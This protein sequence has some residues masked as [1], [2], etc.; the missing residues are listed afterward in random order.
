M[1]NPQLETF[2]RVADAGSFN[3]AAE[4]S[5][6][7]S[8]AVI[9]QINLL[10][11]DLD[12]KLFVRTHRGLTLTKAGV[13]LYNDAKYIIQYCRDSVVRAKNAMQEDTNVIRIGVSPITPTQV[14]VDLWPKIHIHCPEIKFQLVPF[15][16]T[17]EN[18]REILRNMGQH[19]D[20][21]T[22]IFDDT[23]LEVR[24]CAVFEISR[25]PL[26]C[27]VSIYHPLA[28]KNR[29][30][31]QDLYGQRLMMMHRGWSRHVDQLRDAIWERHSEIEIVDFDFYDVDV[32]NRCENGNYLLMAT[33]NCANVHPLIKVIPV[34]W[35]HF[36]PFGLLH[37]KT[38]SETVARF[39]EAVRA[40]V[41]ED[42]KSEHLWVI[43]A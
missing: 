18:A 16:N 43:T 38:P 12:V 25:E 32:F 5:Y 22:G 35:P 10:E 17:P 4:E 3:K 11:A 8:T 9:K 29:L 15:E 34:E 13:S 39:L 2:L 6:I 24:Q 42:K 26:G 28:Q 30:T 40:V 21:V 27:A 23:M 14:L 36:I 19:I 37:A 33:R 41:K 31:V 7:T 20:V 1:Y